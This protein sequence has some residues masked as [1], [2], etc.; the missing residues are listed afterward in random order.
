[1]EILQAINKLWLDKISLSKNRKREEFQDLAD[2]AMRFYNGPHDFLYSGSYSMKSRG[3][4][5]GDGDEIPDPCFKMTVNKVAELVELFLPVLYHRNPV[6]TVT[7][8]RPALDPIELGLPTMA[9]MMFQPGMPPPVIPPSPD[10]IRAKLLAWYLNYSVNETNLKQEAR[11]AIVE[12]LIKG[13]GVLWTELLTLWN[14]TK[15]PCSIYDSVDHLLLDP[16]AE[17]LRDAKWCARRRIRPVWEV[18]EEFGLM[19]GTIKGQQESLAQASQVNVDP[20]GSWE[21]SQGAT[22]DLV[23]YYEVYSRMGIGP[24]MKGFPDGYRDALDNFGLNVY[25]VVCDGVEYPLNLPPEMVDAENGVSEF[26]QRI[27]WH[28]PFYL[29]PAHPWPFVHLD[30]HEIPGKIWP[31]SHIA[32]AMG[33]QKFLDWAYSFLAGKVRLNS[34]E[35]VAF[36]ATA[37]DDIKSAI[38]NGGDLTMVELTPTGPRSIT[39]SVQFLQHPQM[40]GDIF[41]VVQAIEHNFEKRTGLS[42]LM[43]GQSNRQ[44]RSA[45][46]ANV[47]REMLTVRPDDMAECV[48]NWMTQ[49]ARNEAIAVRVHVSAEDVAP[50]FNEQAQPDPLSPDQTMYGPMTMAWAGH[51]SSQDVAAIVHEM[52]YRVESGSARKPNKDREV[53]N[54][55]ESAQT[56]V[57]VLMQYWQATGDPGPINSWLRKWAKSRD[58]EDIVEDISLKAPPPPPPSPGAAKEPPPSIP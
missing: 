15:M 29:D 12:A 2:D 9:D 47:K 35:Y 50:L 46:E 32:P 58:A 4:M 45:S 16:D 13:R 19:R 33:E 24:R 21:R 8:R 10:I 38:E 51:V 23:T 52:E 28:T 36:D 53:Q 5:V 3:F 56:V 6:R 48:E 25:L 44:L 49:A 40:N 57:P 11:Q 1:M 39:E 26:I 27:Q 30:F 34:R 31:M 43:Y 55:D 37:G 18:E 14:G 17:R 7:P 41:N 20:T 22:N 42:E 54:I